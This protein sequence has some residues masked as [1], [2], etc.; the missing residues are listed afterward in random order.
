MATTLLIDGPVSRGMWVRDSVTGKIGVIQ[1]VTWVKKPGIN[2]CV[3]FPIND[4]KDWEV[5]IEKPLEKGQAPWY[6]ERQTEGIPAP[7]WTQLVRDNETNERHETDLFEK[8]PSL[9]DIQK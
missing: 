8:Y 1:D 6:V 3:W 2:I 9:R 7:S 5:D 4:W